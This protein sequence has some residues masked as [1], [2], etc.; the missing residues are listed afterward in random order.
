MQV[1]R[2]V[3]GRESASFNDKIN[4]RMYVDQLNLMSLMLDFDYQL[5]NYDERLLTGYPARQYLRHLR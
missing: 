5:H 1:Q 2:A 4:L 3:R